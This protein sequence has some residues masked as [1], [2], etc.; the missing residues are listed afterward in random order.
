MTKKHIYYF[1]YLRF[2]S[3]IGVIY[4]HVAANPLRGDLTT[5]WHGMNLLTSFAFTAVPL[6]FMMSGSLMLNDEKTADVSLMLKK[7]LPRLL[8]PLIL[9]TVIAVLWKLQFR[10]GGIT[11]RGV[12][13]GLVGAINEPAWIH[14]WYMY[15]LIALYVLSPVLCNALR[16]LSREGHIL[17]FVLICL[18]NLKTMMTVLLPQSLKP[19]VQLQIL[20]RLNLM[21]GILPIYF[22]G[23][24][25]GN[26][27]KKIPNLLLIPLAVA[28][29]SL[30]VWGTYSRTTATGAFDSTYMNQL[31]GFEILLAS[32]VF[33]IFKQNVNTDSKFFR[34]IPVIPLSLPIYLMHNILL[35]TMQMKIRVLTF[36]DTLWVTALNYLICYLTMKTVATVKPLCYILTGI[37]YAT[38]CKTCNWVYT[39]K[40]LFQK[41]K[42]L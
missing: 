32:C 37:P 34:R 25:L 3:A 22:L 40:L 15:A 16:S 35:A 29:L 8:I 19:L 4:M 10:L 14:F 36:G 5:G 21:D 30:I 17:I 42:H 27:K 31:S 24:Y 6:F 11:L 13:D 33:L 7:R 18:L 23:Y 12:Y 1:D 20:H 39:Y 26:W 2:I 28:T 41:K 38:A 9:W